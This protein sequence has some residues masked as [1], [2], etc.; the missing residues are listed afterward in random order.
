MLLACPYLTTIKLRIPNKSK[1]K[2]FLL[3]FFFFIDEILAMQVGT[4]T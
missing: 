1:N 2:T 4:I 3:S